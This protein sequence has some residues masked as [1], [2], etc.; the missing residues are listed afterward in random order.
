MVWLERL[1]RA[2][3]P[4]TAI[5]IGVFQGASLA[6]VPPPTIAIGVDPNPT[7]IFPLKTETRIF[8]EESDKFFAAGRLDKLLAGRPLSVGFIDGLHIFEQ[9]LRDFI[10]LE[11]YCGPRSVIM[12]HDTLP[13]DEPTQRRTRETDFHTGDLWKTVLCLKHFRPDLDIFTIE[14]PPTGLTVVIGL[15]PTSRVLTNIYEAAVARFIDTSFLAVERILDN[16]LNVVP[17]E[18]SVVE[19][20]LKERQII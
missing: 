7:L 4:E 20:R 5:E 19:S 12:F 16:V 3:A 6:L 2:L 8:S 17:N 18:W 9:A 10:H 1:Y 11:R 13:L 15:D 14:T